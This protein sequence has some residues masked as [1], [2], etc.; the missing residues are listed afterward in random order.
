MT[1]QQL[2][3]FLAAFDHGSFSAAADTLHLAQPSLSDQVRRLEA[4]LGVRLFERVGRGLVPTQ[5]GEALRPRAEA[6]LAAADGARDAVAEVRELRGG[7][8]SFGAWSNAQFYGVTDMIVELR[9]RYPAM[10]LRMLGLNSS[11]TAEL[12]RSGKLEIGMV[13]LPIDDRGLDLRNMFTDEIVYVSTDPKA[14]RGAVTIERVAARPLVL[15]DATWGNRDPVRRQLAERAQR[16]GVTVEAEV[17]VESEEAALTV[18]AAGIGDAFVARGV[19]IALATRLPKTL[20]WAP[21][22]EPMHDVN[23]FITRRGAPLTPAARAFVEVADARL[24][25][26]QRTVDAHP[27]R[28]MPG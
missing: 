11:D 25:Q 16:A 21:L 18:V 24:A 20:G 9:R 2:K 23:A 1:I 14:L 27:R 7:V 3:Y 4:E 13:A 10:R 19:M 6:V 28:R 12:V 8:A 26:V 17:E 5:A 22:A 15:S